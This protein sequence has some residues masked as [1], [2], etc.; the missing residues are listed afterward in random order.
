MKK[1]TCYLLIS[2]I[3]LLGMLVIELCFDVSAPIRV[4]NYIVAFILLVVQTPFLS[5]KWEPHYTTEKILYIV[6]TILLMLFIV[7][8]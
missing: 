5:K 3:L 4:L 2:N 8:L 6:F 7:F 1:I